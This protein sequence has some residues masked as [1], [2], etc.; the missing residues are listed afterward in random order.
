MTYFTQV[1]MRTAGQTG[2]GLT[3]GAGLGA[4]S[5]PDNTGRSSRK[6]RW[7]ATSGGPTTVPVAPVTPAA[8]GAAPVPVAGGVVAA[9]DGGMGAGQRGRAKRGRGFS[10]EGTY[11]YIFSFVAI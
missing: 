9:G 11:R 3:G 2:A 7:D 4:A 5:T 10:D 1:A 8:A 6:S